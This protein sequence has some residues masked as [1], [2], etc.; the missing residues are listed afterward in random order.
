[1]SWKL[2]ENELPSQGYLLKVNYKST[3]RVWNMFKVNNKD[4]RTTPLQYRRSDV[5]IVN[6]EHISVLAL[7]LLLLLNI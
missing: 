4:I 7:F 2:T 6:S 5:F 1:M 3:S